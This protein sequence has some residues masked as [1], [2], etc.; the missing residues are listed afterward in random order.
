MSYNATAGIDIIDFLLHSSI[1]VLF[2][3]VGFDLID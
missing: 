1:D 2:V 3:S